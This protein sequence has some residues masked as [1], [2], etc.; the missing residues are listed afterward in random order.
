MKRLLFLMASLAVCF[1]AAAQI[2]AQKAAAEAAKALEEAPKVEAPAAK[3]VYWNNSVM[4][5]FNFGQSAFWN[6]AKGGNNNYAMTAYVDAN[7]NYARD[8]ISW[9]NR[10]QLDYGIMYSEDKPLI[11]KTKDRILLES[12]WGYKATKTLNYTASFTFL[13]QF[14]N[15]YVYKTPSVA[16]AT[17]QDWKDARVLKS[18]CFSPAY[19]TLGLGMDWVPNNWLTINFAPITSGLTVV[20]DEELRKN[21]GMELKSKYEDAPEPLLPSYYRS[22]RFEFGAQL[23]ADA[24]VKI[25]DNF[26]ASTQLIIFSNYLHNPQ[27]FRVNWDNRFMWKLNRFFTLT[28]TTN[29]IYDDTVLIVDEDHPDGRRLIQFSD[30]L[31]FG[32]TYTF[33]SKKK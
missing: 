26:D 9:K 7:A 29:L 20:A 33:A 8:N 18:G 4:T 28:V 23:K 11:Q 3:P 22:V 13:N 21:Y 10:L 17:K 2:D 1:S 12:T 5:Q 32:F 14:S 27:N 15:G 30:A 24:K 25:N 16:D 31:Q 19:I 6:W